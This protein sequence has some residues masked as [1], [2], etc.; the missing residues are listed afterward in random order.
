MLKIHRT[1]LFPVSYFYRCSAVKNNSVKFLFGINVFVKVTLIV[2]FLF[3]LLPQTVLAKIS[4]VEVMYDAKGTDTD[5]EWVKIVNDNESDVEISKIKL[6]IN[7]SNHLIK[8]L[9]GSTL[10]Y[11]S[12]SLVL[13]D[14][15]DKFKVNYPSYAGK[16]FDSSFTLTNTSGSV[17]IKDDKNIVI[18]S[19]SYDSSMGAAGDGNSLQKI[20]GVWKATSPT[21]IGVAD[22]SATTT[23]TSTDSTSSASNATTSSATSSINTNSS[24]NTVTRIV[25][26][27]I[28]THSGTEE[29]SDYD[30]NNDLK[31]TSGRD[32]LAYV[33]VPISFLAKSNSSVQKYV[34]SFGDGSISEGQKISHVYRFPGEYNVVLNADSVD[35]KAV[36]RS[37][38]KVL[39]PKISLTEIKPEYITLKNNG[40]YEIN[41]DGWKLVGVDNTYVIPSDTIIG[42]QKEVRIPTE[43]L[44]FSKYD[45][46]VLNN[47]SG[48]QIYQN[49]LIKQDNSPNM[50]PSTSQSTSTISIAT[51]ELMIN[52]AD[53]E[54]FVLAYKNALEASSIKT[55]TTE[56]E[57][58][59]LAATNPAPAPVQSD[60]I[61]NNQPA[62]VISAYS[63]KTL[64][65][66]AGNSE[67]ISTTSTTS[68]TTPTKNEVGFWGGLWSSFV[69]TFYPGYNVN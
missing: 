19:M 23:S 5:R 13:V 66:S 9:A 28:S 6:T 54:N 18:D 51:V 69:G 55:V 61:L 53:V 24:V 2:I 16:V 63:G 38:V 8:D 39:E 36:S 56:S 50:I 14:D 34:W 45:K 47:P 37:N 17:T 48:R 59:A 21:I 26:H 11:K 3:M 52:K 30:T 67:N 29:L 4:I 10:I 68:D 27:Y 7:D 33:G 43:Y 58:L 35:K 12:D 20:D 15:P 1:K 64:N 60:S 40:E 46:V 62:S 49:T 31:I 65:N 44:N 42:S 57:N 32:R 25:Y 22:T 41:L